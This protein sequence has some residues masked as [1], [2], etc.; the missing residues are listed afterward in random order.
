M[1][2]R[3][4]SSISSAVRS[5]GSAGVPPPAAA[6]AVAALLPGAAESEPAPA[7]AVRLLDGQPQLGLLVGGPRGRPCPAV[8]PVTPWEAALGARVP[9]TTPGGTAK[10]NVPPGSSTGRRGL[11]GEPQPAG[12][13]PVGF[14]QAERHEPAHRFRVQAAAGGDGLQAESPRWGQRIAHPRRRAY[15]DHQGIGGVRR[16]SRAVRAGLLVHGHPMPPSPTPEERS[17][18]RSRSPCGT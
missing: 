17:A 4:R 13:V 9:L 3:Q 1:H 2:R 18:A 7:A 6:G 11:R 14:H 10:V 15:R 5:C 8:W 16:L 12:G